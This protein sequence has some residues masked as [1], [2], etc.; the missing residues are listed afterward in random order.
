[1]GNWSGC[2]R[3]S[4]TERMRWGGGGR[5]WYNGGYLEGGREGN[6]NRITDK[7]K[8]KEVEWDR[9]RGGRHRTPAMSLSCESMVAL[10]CK[11]QHFWRTKWQKAKT[12]IQFRRLCIYFSQT[13]KWHHQHPDLKWVTLCH[14]FI[15]LLL[16][17]KWQLLLW[18]SLA[19]SVIIMAVKEA[20]LKMYKENV[21]RK[22]VRDGCLLKQA[23]N[24]HPG[25]QCSCPVWI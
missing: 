10:G 19:A 15:L 3:Q 16:F 21:C 24:F 12:K 20:Q 17:F 22:E 14:I 25:G 13:V 8:E 2:Q 11:N 4:E 1:M 5:G 7:N 18:Q 9:N 6:K 23:Q